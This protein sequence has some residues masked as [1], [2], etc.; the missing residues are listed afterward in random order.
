MLDRRILSEA[1]YR[2][3]LDHTIDQMSLSGETHLTP[4]NLESRL[5]LVE[6]TRIQQRY[7]HLCSESCRDKGIQNYF[8]K[9]VTCF[10]L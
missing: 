6:R 7:P 2:Y 9:K 8:Y 5:Q 1:Y 3:E 4:Y 10:S